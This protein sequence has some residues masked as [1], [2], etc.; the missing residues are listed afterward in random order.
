MRVLCIRYKRIYFAFSFWNERNSTLVLCHSSHFQT[1][2]RVFLG[3][4]FARGVGT[5]MRFC[6]GSLAFLWFDPYNSTFVLQRPTKN[7]KHIE[8]IFM[9][10]F[11]NFVLED[12]SRLYTFLV[13]NI[14]YKGTIQ[15]SF[16]FLFFGWN[17]F[18]YIFSNIK[19]LELILKYYQYN[20]Y[21]NV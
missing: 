10:E 13:S 14:N 11:F 4:F 21:E 6:L 17:K 18:F 15:F 3:C 9:L 19:V 8:N 1:E 7:W 16:Y 12:T 2:E 5:H 20:F